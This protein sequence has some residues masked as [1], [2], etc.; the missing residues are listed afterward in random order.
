MRL[1]FQSVLYCTHGT[2]DCTGRS[3]F[4]KYMRDVQKIE[5]EQ[6]K[7]YNE[8]NCKN[9]QDNHCILFELKN[10]EMLR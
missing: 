6:Y 7:K 3:A 2:A 5:Y 1:G 4:H 9:Y 8:Y 10:T